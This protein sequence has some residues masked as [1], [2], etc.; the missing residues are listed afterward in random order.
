MTQRKYCISDH[1]YKDDKEK[2]VEK[3]IRG[4]NDSSLS[5]PQELKEGL[6]VPVRTKSPNH[7]RKRDGFYESK[8]MDIPKES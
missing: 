6:K 8:S 7:K 4:G 5:V 2:K 3:I 1:T